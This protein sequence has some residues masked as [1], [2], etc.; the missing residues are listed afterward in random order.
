MAVGFVTQLSGGGEALDKPPRDGMAAEHRS[1][2]V[3]TQPPRQWCPRRSHG[4]IFLS[5][6]L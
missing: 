4:T 1:V 2:G 6:F 3:C 5:F